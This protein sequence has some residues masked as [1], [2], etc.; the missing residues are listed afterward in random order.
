MKGGG[1]GGVGKGEGF[2]VFHF[3]FVCLFSFFS[4]L[5]SAP[6][7]KVGVQQTSTYDIKTN[8]KSR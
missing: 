8:T 4:N 7:Y 5:L 3:L 6:D 2:L 1:G